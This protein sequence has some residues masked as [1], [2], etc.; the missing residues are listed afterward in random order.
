MKRI[1][2][3]ALVSALIIT[4]LDFLQVL[5]GVRTWG[6]DPWLT[7]LKFALV[8]AVLGTLSYLLD[9][10]PHPAK[11]WAVATH[12]LFFASGYLATCLFPNQFYILGAL[13]VLLWIQ[14]LVSR[15]HYKVSNVE[16]FPFAL[17]LITMGPLV[18]L[19]DVKMGG[20]TY[21]AFPGTV[22]YWLPFLWVSG[23]FLTRAL[24]GE[25]AND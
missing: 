24:T 9:P 4:P 20:F 17:V 10:K 19:I 1:L 12:G 8:G 2:I 23:A 16:T 21:I 15:Y 11:P 5:C 3:F 18:E 7:P 25:E 22:P 14:D 6:T 13:T